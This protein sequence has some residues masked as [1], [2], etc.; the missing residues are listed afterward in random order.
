MGLS[1]NAFDAT[2]GFGRIHPG[3]D[4]DLSIR[5]TKLN[6]ET[7][8][9]PKA[10][11]YHKRRISWSK[12][13]QQVYKFGMVRQ[14]LNQWHPETKKITYWF[15]TFF[16]FGLLVSIAL[17]ALGIKFPLIIF[18]LYFFV[19]FI[20]AFVS[21]KSLIVPF[22]SL[23]AIMIQFFGYGFGFLKSALILSMSKKDI[24]QQFPDLF[25]KVNKN[26]I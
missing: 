25:F 8:L 24:E 6:F 5:L 18:G 14:I 9:I 15:P 11:V 2:G 13:Y 7:K 23:I 17:F 10:F 21:S 26:D 20:L 3:E 19:S 16:C 1:K 22:L 4:P 12:F